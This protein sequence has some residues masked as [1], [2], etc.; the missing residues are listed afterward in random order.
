[1]KPN[2]IKEKK[3]AFA[4]HI[5]KPHTQLTEKKKKFVFNISELLKLLT[6][7]VKNIM[8]KKVIIN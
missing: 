6:S 3:F 1:M 4:I 8:N 7:V 5:V 2:I